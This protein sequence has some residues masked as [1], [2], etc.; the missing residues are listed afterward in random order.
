MRW[1]LQS[2]E[3][4]LQKAEWFSLCN[5]GAVFLCKTIQRSSSGIEPLMLAWFWG[6]FWLA[7]L[8]ILLVAA[9]RLFKTMRASVEEEIS[10][11]QE[12]QDNLRSLRLHGELSDEEFRKV[13][14][15]LAAQVAAQDKSAL[16]SSGNS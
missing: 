3:A 8:A 4:R 11:D 5:G 12:I 10:H 2:Q 6:F 15:M 14:A 13:N 1:K 9:V 16:K 7:I